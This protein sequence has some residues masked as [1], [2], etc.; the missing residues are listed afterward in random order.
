MKDRLQTE[1]AL[2][3]KIKALRGDPL[4]F[5]L[6]AFPWGEPDGELADQEGPDEWQREVL[7]AVRDGLLTMNEAIRIAI[8]AGNG[9]GKSALLA[10]LALWALST[11]TDT[12]G[13]I[14]AITDTQLRTRTWAEVSIWFRRLI[15]RHWF[16]ITATAIYSAH[17]DHERTWRIDAVPWSETNP[18]AVA[19]LHNAGKRIIL[20]FDEASG[21]ADVIFDAAEGALTD[22]DTEII[23]VVAG[24]PTKNTGAFRECFGRFAHRWKHWNV[25]TRHSRFADQ[26]QIAKWIADY[27]EDSD[28]VRVHVKG[29][30]PRAGSMQFIGSELVQQA[31]TREATATLY[32]PLLLGVD[33]ARFGEDQ[34]VIYIRKGRDGRTHPPMKFR[35]LDTMQLA[36]KVADVALHFRA[37][38]VF[39]DGGGVGGGVVDRLRQLRVPR[40]YEVNF[41]S[42]PDR[43]L[44][45][46]EAIAYANKR[47]EMWGN[48]REWLK[49]GAIPDDAELRADL[50]GPEYCHVIRDGRDA[51]L[52]E[53]KEDMKRRR[54][55]SPDTGD[56][57]A[58]TFA[59]PVSP[60]AQAGRDYAENQT[61]VVTDW[62]PF[63]ESRSTSRVRSD[64]DPFTNEADRGPRLGV[65][66][67]YS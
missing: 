49:G 45:G 10:W 11:L 39:V 47:A 27:G 15:C 32:D 56:A 1:R 57:L 35:G 36:A 22:K 28:Y 18:Q 46:Q 41:G 14:T 12:R 9:P 16:N 13:I 40:L 51:I 17:P 62:D 26:G 42:K 2:I 6:F 5:V 23:W 54:L 55:A 7:V 61:M 65:P 38:A 33:V 25:D 34:S 8:A 43:A 20:L 31:I 53:A 52:L 63:A 67:D 4:K 60:S 3:D 58:L 30:F 44:P 37:D 21:I 64:F 50:T 66:I 29:E 19:G 24:N 48:L 59:Y